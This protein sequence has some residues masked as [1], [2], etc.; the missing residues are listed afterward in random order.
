MDGHLRV[1]W[2]D[3]GREPQC[4]PDPAYPNGKDMDLSAGAALN[5]TAQLPYP[6]KRCGEYVVTCGS[7]RFRAVVTTAGRPDDPKSVK[8]PCQ[9]FVPGVHT[10]VHGLRRQALGSIAREIPVQYRVEDDKTGVTVG[11][12]P[13]GMAERM[14]SIAMQDGLHRV[15]DYVAEVDIEKGEFRFIK[16]NETVDLDASTGNFITIHHTEIESIVGH[17]VGIGLDGLPVLIGDDRKMLSVGLTIR[18]TIRSYPGSAGKIRKQLDKEMKRNKTTRKAIDGMLSGAGFP[19][20]A[21]AIAAKV[22]DMRRAMLA[23]LQA[24]P[25]APL[26]LQRP[27][28]SAL[29][30]LREAGMAGELI[31]VLADR[32]QDVSLGTD[33]ANSTADAHSFV[34]EHDWRRAFGDAK[35]SG[36]EHGG[37]EIDLPYPIT[38]FEF[39]VSGKRVVALM[40]SA[41]AARP[42]TLAI[43]VKLDAG[44]ALVMVYDVTDTWQ[45]IPARRRHEPLIKRMQPVADMVVQN[46]RAIAIM[47]E[48]Q[49]A[50]REAVRIPAK[51][52]AR[53]VREGKLP[54]SDYHVVAL[55]KRDRVAPRLASE[56]DPDREITRKRLHFVRSHW[57][58]YADHR[59]KVPWHLRGDPD[60]GFIDKHYKL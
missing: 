11:A 58:Q 5:C 31:V 13:P 34:V 20:T 59:T 43:S 3:G 36:E 56:L 2:H 35:I 46:A 27:D 32:D 15:A 41:D 24:W 55:A 54:F 48:S 6:A 16:R 57:R 53:R 37:G 10:S 33:Y 29:H 52:N 44:W 7:C 22:D 50:V 19:T 1:E 8:V 60:L 26:S 25:P 23:E 39:V 42:S 30:K 18:A 49:V 14:R 40:T 21:D 47:L 51:L 12:V 45:A 4:A 28:G 17:S 38:V 9:I